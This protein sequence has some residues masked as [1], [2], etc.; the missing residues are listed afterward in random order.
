MFIVFV[1][2]IY[3]IDL[4]MDKTIVMFIVICDKRFF[5][6][7]YYSIMKRNYKWLES[8]NYLERI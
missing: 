7:L 5:I 8:V 6:V 2:K 3:I 1:F 4:I